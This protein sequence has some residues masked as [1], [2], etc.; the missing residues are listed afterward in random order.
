MLVVVLSLQTLVI[1]DLADIKKSLVDHKKAITAIAY[2]QDRQQQQ[3]SRMNNQIELIIQILE[4]QTSQLEYLL[5]KVEND[6][7]N[8]VEEKEIPW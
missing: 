1:A 6:N 4:V 8:Q 7:V 5:D 3:S 2:E